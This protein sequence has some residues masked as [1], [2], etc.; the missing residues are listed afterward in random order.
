MLPCPNNDTCI[1]SSDITLDDDLDYSKLL[2]Y[3]NLN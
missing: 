2:K 3:S 1:G